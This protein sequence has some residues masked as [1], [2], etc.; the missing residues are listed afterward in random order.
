MECEHAKAKEIY[1]EIM[2]WLE[3]R[4]A[5]YTNTPMKEG[6]LSIPILRPGA[7]PGELRFRKVITMG[8]SSFAQ[9]IERDDIKIH[10]DPNWEALRKIEQLLAGDDALPNV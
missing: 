1:Q 5:S 4:A 6:L 9:S 10:Y 2:L 8:A 7:E 3:G